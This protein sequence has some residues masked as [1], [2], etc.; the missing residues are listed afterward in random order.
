MA[1]SSDYK[2]LSLG[3]LDPNSWPRLATGDFN[4]DGAGDIVWRSSQDT[5]VRLWE[6]TD[7]R[8]T[9]TPQAAN[10]SPSFS[11]T[12]VPYTGDLDGD[13]VSDVVW[14]W[15]F[16]VG[17]PG[18]TVTVW[19]I[20]TWLMSSNSATP[21]S[22][23]VAQSG[24][25][26]LLGLGD[27]DHDSLRRADALYRDPA[28]SIVS[29]QLSG[30]GQSTIGYVPNDWQ[31]KG[32]GDFNGDG[33]SDVVWHNATT[34]LISIWVMGN[35][36]IASNPL[37]GTVPLSSGWS[38][39]GVGDVDHD[40]I[41]DII[42]RHTSSVLSIWM[43]N[44][45][46]SV[47]EYGPAFS[48][49]PSAT[50]AGVLELGA[51]PAPVNPYVS[52]E[53]LQ[54]GHIM[55]NVRFHG[56]PSRASDSIE[57]L[58]S[59][60]RAHPIRV[61]YHLAINPDVMEATV[62][63]S[64]F[65]NGVRGCFQIRAWEQG[66][67][68]SYS[69]PVCQ[70]GLPAPSPSLTWKMDDG[71]G[72]DQNA[73]GA[74]DLVPNQTTLGYLR[75]G[76]WPVMLDACASNDA[77][78]RGT[79]TNYTWTVALPTGPTTIST[80]NC[81]VTGFLAP[82]GPMTTT[83]T[84]TT[85]DG[86]AATASTTMDAKRFLI[87]SLG[88]SYASGEGNPIR[89]LVVAPN[90]TVQTPAFWGTSSDAAC[91]R[92]ANSA[93]AR[94]ALALER[95]DPHSAV[96]FF[97]AACTG[98]VISNLITDAQEPAGPQIQQ[99]RNL[100]CPAGSGGACNPSAMPQIDAL[101]LSISGND[102]GFGDIVES[103]AA[104]YDACSTDQD[105][106]NGKEAQL[107]LVADKLS[108][109]GFSLTALS[110]QKTFITEYPDG[111]HTD[112]TSTCDGI[113][114]EGA[115][116]GL[117]AHIGPQDLA[118]AAAFIRRLDTIIYGVALNTP[119]WNYVNNVNYQ[120][121]THGY[122]MA[123]H[124]ETHYG[125]S[126]RKQAD[127][128]GTLHPNT[129]GLNAIALQ[130]LSKW[131]DAGIAPSSAGGA[132]PPGNAVPFG[133]TPLL[134]SSC[135]VLKAGEGLKAGTNLSSCDGRFVLVMQTD[136]RLVLYQVTPNGSSQLWANPVSGLTTDSYSILQGDGN[137]VTYTSP[138]GG[139]VWASNTPGYFGAYLVV[140]NDGNVVVYDAGNNWRWQS[141]TCC[142]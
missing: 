98:A 47:R 20:A 123:D 131:S 45:D 46:G 9:Q 103:C 128:R 13:G 125:E 126:E 26:Q 70:P 124:W 3:T 133:V 11:S 51:P 5:S 102:A 136:G 112:H 100:L 81:R 82:K 59:D 118:W 87:V 4:A 99:V 33:T 53:Y 97:S 88:D 39:Q 114:L 61:A 17:T 78:A 63:T 117:D 10:A 92:T 35:G 50:F 56:Q 49:D 12:A 138:A 32:I 86:R 142:H 42:W 65:F 31:V 121:D 44:A 79:I 90:G 8:V 115:A 137:F 28:S 19:N 36:G 80:P 67:V 94:S 22:A 52:S 135:G 89:D 101:M 2:E 25:G 96:A 111:V 27:F 15:S 60:S 68:S 66:R 91:H 30:G 139:P 134:S 57:V 1:S 72:F 83:L 127:E 119:G 14:S 69:Y 104:A 84:V 38:I 76:K 7:T 140:Q 75:S 108:T 71:F 105:F 109:L 130:I 6:T 48:V 120:F 107:D 40:G 77:D 95:S 129:G 110:A 132:L 113:T 16:G 141:G 54:N 73:D 74:I 18:G 106:T 24:L 41:S 34:G 23:S 21:R 58:E 55:M 122:C 64:Q 116:F 29:I 93:P 85:Q 62:D 43:M 37:P